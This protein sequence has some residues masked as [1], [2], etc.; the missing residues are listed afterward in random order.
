MVDTIGIQQNLTAVFDWL[1]FTIKNVNLPSVITNILKLDTSDF[2]DLSKG[3]FGYNA[4]QKWANGNLFLLYNVGDEKDDTG[5]MLPLDRDKMGVHVMITGTGCRMYENHRGLR[6][7]IIDCVALGKDANI[8]RIDIAIDDT[9]DSIINY[10]RI[11]RAALN[12][13]MTSRWSKWDEVNSR[14][15]SDGTY[16]GRTMYFGSQASDIFCRVYDKT[17]ERKVNA[18]NDEEIPENWTRLELVYKR[19][20][21]QLL[22]WHLVDNDNIGIV[23]RAT[24]NNYIRFLQRPRDNGDTNKR[25][26]PSTRWWDALIANVGR[27]SLTIKKADRTIEQ[28]EEWADRQISPTLAAI[29]LAHE[30]DTDWLTSIVVE[31]KSRLRQKHWDAIAQYKDS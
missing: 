1:E 23:L 25:R 6:D 29:M 24:L 2:T 16:I 15:I 3:R 10:D 13:N 5:K 31:G 14:K 12:S 30:G 27:L 8:T 28:M 20:R 19:E 18:D 17:L 9:A 22:A 26:W 11:H 21:A 7:L 4:Q